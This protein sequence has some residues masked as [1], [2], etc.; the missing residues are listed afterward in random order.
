M[1]ILIPYYKRDASKVGV[2]GFLTH[3]FFTDSEVRFRQANYSCMNPEMPYL[4][5]I[6]IT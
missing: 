1:M 5:V 6:M 4:W 3:P 2:T